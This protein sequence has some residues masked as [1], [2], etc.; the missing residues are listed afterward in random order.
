MTSINKSNLEQLF[1]ISM[2]ANTSGRNI[3]LT[4]IEPS[5]EERKFNGL[6]D[7]YRRHNMMESNIK[8]EK[9][10]I[11]PSEEQINKVFKNL[12]IKDA[13]FQK[14]VNDMINNLENNK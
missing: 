5:N 4:T 11:S 2:L 12:Y 1:S 8:L 14:S 9:T 6:Y 10:L 3:S 13:N 7:F